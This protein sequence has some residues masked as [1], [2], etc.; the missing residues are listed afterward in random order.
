MSEPKKRRFPVRQIASLAAAALL[1]FMV[2]F[3][4]TA[5]WGRGE[6]DA[7]GKCRD[8]VGL[9]AYTQDGWRTIKDTCTASELA[10]LTAEFNANG[11]STEHIDLARRMQQ[12]E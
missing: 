2:V 12:A 4:L 8:A 10:A 1:L 9:A 5:N 11:V 3:L 6:A 7:S